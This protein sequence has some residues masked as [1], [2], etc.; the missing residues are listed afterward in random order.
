MNSEKVIIDYL[1]DKIT[2]SE[3]INL[4]DLQE[5]CNCE[6]VGTHF[7]EKNGEYYCEDC[8]YII[9]C[10]DKYDETGMNPNDF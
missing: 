2:R 7:K 8:E 1:N 9:D 4:Y 5:C 10:N 3:L 6:A